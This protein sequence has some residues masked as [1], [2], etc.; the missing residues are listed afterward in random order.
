MKLQ[1]RLGQRSL[2]LALCATALGAVLAAQSA[3][4]VVIAVDFSSNALSTVPFSINGVYLNVVTGVAS[5]TNV[6]GYDINPYF[7]GSTS[8]PA[9]FRL[10]TSSVGGGG[11][12]GGAT[13]TPL[14]V[15]SVVGPAGTFASGVS[16]ANAATPGTNYY[17]F[18]FLN[19]ATAA[20][21]YGYIVVAQSANP[22]LAGSVKIL[23][24]AYENT[25]AAIGVAAVVPE[26]STT[27]LMLGGLL[28]AGALR[29]RQSA[30]RR[31]LA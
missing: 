20:I 25:G 19:E 27:L 1:F 29:L 31:D 6:A 12:L 13:A 15:G 21:N 14:T 22:P 5:P 4:A 10:F 3:H 26:P 30:G 23:G 2:R 17:G 8:P 16:N 28:A 9:I 18:R 7:S 24:Y 11:V